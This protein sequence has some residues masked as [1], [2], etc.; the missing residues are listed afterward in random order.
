MVTPS[1]PEVIDDRGRGQPAK[2]AAPCRRHVLA[3]LRQSLDVRLV[4]DG[5]FPGDRRAAFFAPGEGLVDHDRL[6]HAARIVAPIE[7]EI[8]AR[9]AGAIAEM[10][11]APHQPPG[12]PL[13]IGI[14]QELVRIETKAPLRIIGAVHAIAVELARY[15]VVEIAVPDI[16]GPLGQRDALELAPA[17]AVEQAELDLC[18]HWPKTARNWFRVRPRSRPADTASRAE[19]RT[20]PLRDEKNCSKGRNDKADLGNCALVQRPHGAA[21]PDIAAAI[22]APHRY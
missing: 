14:D 19:R 16:L 5:V 4:D 17:L 18:R 13:G 1:S 9:V 12:Q 15:D 20:L 11:V 10:R 7:G 22:D 3:Q 6:R 21:V 8:G 2:G